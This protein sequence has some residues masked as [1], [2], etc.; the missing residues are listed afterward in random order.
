MHSSTVYHLYVA[1]CA[2]CPKS[3][4]SSP[5]VWCPFLFITPH[6][7]WKSCIAGLFVLQ[8]LPKKPTFPW[9]LCWCYFKKFEHLLATV[10]S[11]FFIFSITGLFEKNHVLT[12]NTMWLCILEYDARRAGVLNSFVHIAF[13]MPNHMLMLSINKQVKYQLVPWISS[14]VFTMTWEIGKMDVTI[15]TYKR[16]YKVTHG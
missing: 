14:L 9:I 11:L 13:T 8:F 2:H 12:C 10:F 3:S 6:P 1:L 15:T 4:L 5:Y 7:S 16:G